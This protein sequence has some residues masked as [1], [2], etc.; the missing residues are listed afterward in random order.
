MLVM[1]FDWKGIVNHESEPR[2]QTLN[3]LLYQ[4]VLARFWNAVRSQRPELW[5]NH[6]WM[7]HHDNAPT[8]ASFLICSYLE[9]HP[10]CPIHPI[11]RT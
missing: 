10:L 4:E 3:K 5:E 7:L 8:H 6:T 9:K 11:L 2:G 1:V